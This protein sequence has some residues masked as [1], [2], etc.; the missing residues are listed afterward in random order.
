MLIKRSTWSG[1]AIRMQDEFTVWGLIIVL[2]KGGRVK[3]IGNSVNKSKFYSGINWEQIKAGNSCYHSVQN[4]LSSSLLS[5]NLKVYT[6]IILPL[7][8]MG[9]KL[10]SSHWGRSVG[11]GCLR[12]WCWGEYFGPERDEVTWEWRKLHNEELNDLTKYC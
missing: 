3:I 2:W 7:F 5:K 8:C 6:N 12:I 1:L 9:V 10:G 4:I 11:W